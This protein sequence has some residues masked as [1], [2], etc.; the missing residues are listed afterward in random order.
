MAV[1][2]TVVPCFI[3]LVRDVAWHDAVERRREVLLQAGL[4]LDGGQ[5]R[6]RAG[7]KQSHLS[8]VQAD[9]IQQTGCVRCQV[10]HLAVTAGGD[11]DRP[12]RDLDLLTR[13]DS[14]HTRYRWWYLPAVRS[15][16]FVSFVHGLSK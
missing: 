7:D 2:V 10:E 5:R 13:V 11:G 6:G 3:V 1:P 9:R 4:V 15:W 12:C 8:F 14:W 16:R